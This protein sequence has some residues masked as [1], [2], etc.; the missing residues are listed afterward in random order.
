LVLE[1]QAYLSERLR[2]DTAAGTPPAAPT[3]GV[4][5]AVV[6]ANPNLEG[7]EMSVRRHLARLHRS[8]RLPRM[9][10]NSMTAEQRSQVFRVM[11]EDVAENGRRA[12]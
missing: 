8:G 12:R 5:E 11:L 7:S 3:L 9:S 2:A 1:H 4:A 6:Q 10:W